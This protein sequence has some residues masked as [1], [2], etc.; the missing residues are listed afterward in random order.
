LR[1]D[2]AAIAGYL[3]KTDEMDAAIAKS[4]FLYA[5]QTDRDYDAL[6]KAARA[7]GIEVAKA[8]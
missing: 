1:S 3:G 8:G 7:G 6:V 5:E 2:P 4:A